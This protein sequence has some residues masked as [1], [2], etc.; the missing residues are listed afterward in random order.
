MPDD[1]TPPDASAPD[2]PA[3]PEP[4][5]YDPAAIE[6]RWQAAWEAAGAFRAGRRPEAEKAYVLEMFPYPS[7]RIHIGHV[8]NYAMGDVIARHR[9]ARGFDVLHP[10]GWDAF[11][12]PAENAAMASGGH[13]KDWTHANIA[14]MRA[15]MKPLGFSIDWSREIATCDPEYYGQQQALFLDMLDAGLVYRKSATVN[16][17]PV[18]MTVLA[19]EQVEDGRGWR[20]G[21]LVERRELT[22]WFFRI[23][24]FAE[25]LLDALDGL[26]QWPPKVKAMQANWIGRSRGLQMTFR[27]S[28][29]AHGFDGVEVYTTRPDTLA[30]ASFVAVSPD[31]PLAKRAGGRRPC[32]GGLQRPRRGAAAPPRRRSRRPR[33]AVTTRGSRRSTRSGRRTPARLG[34]QLRAD[35][36]RHGG[37]LRLPGARPARSGLRGE[38]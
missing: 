27:L 28:E 4:A 25:D 38:V 9:I 35:G 10:M 36:L 8:R 1:A 21:A 18:E 26:D 5:R 12:L 15:Q 37:D 20:S 23:S 34:R 11:G 19:N 31:H 14:D 17:D 6:P 3:R 24:E 2:A 22:Q 33:S 29:P 13:P 30:G 16:W 32:A 7:G